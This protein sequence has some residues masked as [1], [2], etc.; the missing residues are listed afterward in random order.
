MKK[1]LAKIFC[2]LVV[3][4]VS[5]P[6]SMLVWHKIILPILNWNWESI[7]DTLFVCGVMCLAF[8]VVLVMGIIMMV[9]VCGFI[10]LWKWAFSKEI[11]TDADLKKKL[12]SIWKEAVKEVE[13]EVNNG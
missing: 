12:D 6:I 13:D 9:V 10:N 1:T 3:I 2:I 8:I 11:K 5:I 4:A 7:T